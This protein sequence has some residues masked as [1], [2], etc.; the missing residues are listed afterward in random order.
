MPIPAAAA[1]RKPGKKKA[2]QEILRGF[3]SGSVDQNLIVALAQ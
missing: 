2:A 3:S 1:S